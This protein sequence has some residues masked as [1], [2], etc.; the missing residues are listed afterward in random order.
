MKRLV[1]IFVYTFLFTFVSCNCWLGISHWRFI[2]DIR[3]A[4]IAANISPL[5]RSA[6]LPLCETL[7]PSTTVI[8]NFP[9][10]RSTEG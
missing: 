2:L 7:I 3:S 10:F 8:I 6:T 5:F 1:L 9:S 4:W